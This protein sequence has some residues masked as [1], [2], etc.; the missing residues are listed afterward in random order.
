[1][2]KTN[3]K[4]TFMTQLSLLLALEIIMSFTV[5]GFISIP[6]V[7]ITLMHIPVIVGAILL[8]YK[9]GI[10]LGAAF[11]ILSM[12]RATFAAAGPVDVMFNPAASGNPVGSIVM[13][14]LPRILLGVVAVLVYNLLKEKIRPALA[15]SIAAIAAT[16][17]HSFGVL[18]L[19]SVLFSALPLKEVFAT[20][21]GFNCILEALAA[22]LLTSAICTGVLKYKKAG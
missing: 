5:L 1:M 21:I 3:A 10:F 11:G 13:A 15:M 14:V 17:V 19:L 18:G 7:S 4:L 20:L 9:G 12:I 16:F 6:P 22:V 2:K 8:G